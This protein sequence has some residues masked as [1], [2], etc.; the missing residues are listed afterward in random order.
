VTI[1]PDAFDGSGIK[2]VVLQRGNVSLKSFPKGIHATV[3][4][5]PYPKK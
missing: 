5:L 1:A 4:L 3:Q 2:Y